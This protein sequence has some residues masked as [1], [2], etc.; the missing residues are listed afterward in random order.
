MCYNW[1]RKDPN[2]MVMILAIVG[3]M[4]FA[5]C[6]TKEQS[7]PQK[8]SSR[9]SAQVSDVQIIPLDDALK[10]LGD[11]MS[12]IDPDAVL[13]KSGISKDIASI[14]TYYGDKVLTKSGDPVP[15]AYIVNFSNDGGFAVLA[16]NTTI[17]PVVAYSE[18]GSFSKAYLDEYYSSVNNINEELVFDEE[19]FPLMKERY[20][21]AVAAIATTIDR[22][23]AAGYS[24]TIKEN[25]NQDYV[26]PLV[27]TKWCQGNYESDVFPENK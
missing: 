9:D 20:D 7:T 6:C 3:L 16:A 17:D 18:S 23:N 11:F 26:S 2:L 22:Q 14:E 1:F 24:N 15:D 8:D 19:G 5:V 27:K 13:T 21:V 25:K 12:E 10:T 4:L